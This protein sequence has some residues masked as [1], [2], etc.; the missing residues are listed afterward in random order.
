MIE[1]AAISYPETGIIVTSRRVGYHSSPLD[2][3]LFTDFELLPFTDSQIA[4]YA[5]AWFNL[6]D[7]L[8]R[9]DLA[10]MV[11]G[12]LRDIATIRDLARESSHDIAIVFPVCL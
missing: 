2:G 5:R 6:A 11:T 1:A 9:T 10:S 4:D 8:N 12:F 7:H 3:S